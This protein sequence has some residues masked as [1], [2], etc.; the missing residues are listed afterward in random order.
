MIKCPCGGEPHLRHDIRRGIF[1]YACNECGYYAEPSANEVTAKSRWSI[2]SGEI[3]PCLGCDHRPKIRKSKL[4]DTWTFVCTGCGWRGNPSH[5]SEAAY[6]NWHRANL[7]NSEHVWDLWCVRF[8][9]LKGQLSEH[10]KCR[11]ITTN[12]IQKPPLGCGN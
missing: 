1:L 9:E 8:E 5:T 7:P 4:R 2:A 12:S 3:R 11:P 6:V 10:K